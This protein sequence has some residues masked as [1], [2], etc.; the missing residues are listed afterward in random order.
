MHNYVNPLEL[1][2]LETD[3]SSGFD[4][5]SIRKAKKTLLAEIELSDTGTIIYKGIELTKS[6]CIRLIDELEHK[7][8]KDFHL[9]IFENTDLNHFLT[10]GD[11]TF[12]RTY[13]IQSIYKDPEFIEFI[14]PYFS[15]QYSKAL[16]RNFKTNNF[17]NVKSLL[18]IKPVVRESHIEDCYKST[19]TALKET[20]NEIIKITQD[21]E[22]KRSEHIENNFKNLPFLIK[23][24]V[25]TELINLLPSYFQSI[26]NQFAETIKILA[27]TI[28][29]SPYG[30]YKPAFELI[31]I[32][33]TIQTYGLVKQKIS[34]SYYIIKN[35]FERSIPKSA[36]SNS[37]KTTQ[38][39]AA[40]IQ[41]GEDDENEKVQVN[42]GNK[43]NN[44][45]LYWL[46]LS[47][48]NAIG[49]FYNP[50]QKVILGL[51]LFILL[52]QSIAL[53]KDKDFSIGLFLKK[54]I[55]LI[56][57]AS[58]GLYYEI[59]A[60]LYV[61][62]NF[63]ANLNL[64]VD[65]IYNKGKLSNR[66]FGVW[67]YAAGAI[68]I[69]FLY[70]NYFSVVKSNPLNSI[71][72]PEEKLTD[73]ECYQKGNTYFQMS[74]FKD[75]IVYFD[76]AI[77]LNA[78][79]KEA[80]GDRG[81][82][83]ANLGQY[84]A[85]V[86]DFQKAEDLG[87]STSNLYSNW[88]Y[89]YY[90]LKQPEKA[91]IYFE[92]SIEI[93][94]NNG[95]AFRWRGEIKYDK[96]DNKGAEEDY[97]LAISKSPTASNYFARGL[98]YYYLKDYRKALIDMDKAI[99]INPN[100]AQY[101]FDRGDTKDLINDFDGACRDWKIAKEKGYNVPDYKIK[102][103]TPQ[104]VDVSNGE[105]LGCNGIKP[106]YNYGLDNKLLVSVGSNANVAVK[107]INIIN[108]KCIRYVFIKKNSSYSIRNIP[109]GRYYL[110]I[111]YGDDWSVI[112]GQPS[113]TGRFTKNTLFEKGEDVL[114]YNLVYSGNG[115]QVPSFSLK[116]N[117]ILG[118]DKMN[119]FNTDKID[120][121]NFYNE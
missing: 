77:S 93:D 57:A 84:E 85:A 120:E 21:V 27:V 54:N 37:S 52:V 74:Y 34:Q 119:S 66:R 95:N 1:L 33:S 56:G 32:A 19:Y 58:F 42:E 50:V 92:K 16:S 113:C 24:R 5:Q 76:K 20:E 96:N 112:D 105:L 79:Y 106:K 49:F 11:L 38:P 94:P 46:F 103:C 69:T 98:A 91:L 70:Y 107:L 86:L 102:R 110:K 43:E 87:L 47:V 114:D 59:L 53:R 115:Y 51:S 55:I 4:L 8:K 45:I 15:V 108:D 104:L 25:N 3:P 109:E 81:A 80:Y 36:I 7:D 26:R 10:T 13:K 73:K 62:Y 78:N 83:K 64:L 31:E 121:N 14:S 22:F 41:F 71:A 117:L 29:N 48:A 97:T 111:A 116:L 9:F 89:A 18:S 88:G 39:K 67:H 75:A 60:Q 72:I 61:S 65:A 99:Q 6:D 44:N 23:D 17:N 28:N 90:K 2:N 68:I 63:I 82:S 35:N 12:F 40:I 118:E 100:M 30:K 101:Y